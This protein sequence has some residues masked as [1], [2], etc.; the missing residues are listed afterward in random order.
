MLDMLLQAH[1]SSELGRL[2]FS[3]HGYL[4]PESVSCKLPACEACSCD[5]VLVYTVQQALC[6]YCCHLHVNASQPHGT[7]VKATQR[8]IFPCSKKNADTIDR[9]EARDMRAFNAK[10]HKYR[11]LVPQ[12]YHHHHKVSS[13]WELLSHTCLTLTAL[14]TCSTIEGV[15]VVAWLLSCSRSACTAC[16]TC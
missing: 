1:C 3:H 10:A 8:P 4:L 5:H 11:N 14:H 13:N 2:A 16:G 12:A 15:A 7:A 9:Q 6:D